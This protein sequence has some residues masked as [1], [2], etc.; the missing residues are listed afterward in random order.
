MIKVNQ[1]S[2]VAQATRLQ[3]RIDIAGICVTKS[4]V[5]T[6]PY[7]N[8]ED[9]IALRAHLPKLAL[10]VSFRKDD[11]FLPSEVSDQLEATNANF[12]EYT[13]VDFA[14][15]EQFESELISLSK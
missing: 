14:K 5:A 3:N 13:P 11:S 8:V 7:L 6:V 2:S 4:R 10:S 15:T 9:A 12:F 1:I